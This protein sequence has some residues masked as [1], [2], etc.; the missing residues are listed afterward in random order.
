[1]TTIFRKLRQKRHWDSKPWLG[2]GDSQSDAAKCLMTDDNRLSV[3]ILENSNVQMERVVA[4][5]A[6]TRDNLEH[7]DLAIAPEEVLEVCG[8]RHAKV[9]AKTPDSEVND[10][11]LDLVELTLAKIAELATA[12]RNEGKIVRYQRTDVRVAVQKSLRT[13]NIVPGNINPKLVRALG[14]HGVTVPTGLGTAF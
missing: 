3:F 13:A 2:T 5:L 14:K 4:A 12:I 8:I 7:V 11:H 10:W 9:P 1:M 6:L